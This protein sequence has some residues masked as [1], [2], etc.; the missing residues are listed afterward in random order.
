MNL[1]DDAQSLQDD[2]VHL[3]RLIHQEP[4]IGLQLPRTQEKVLTALDG[5]PGL[6]LTT[7]RGLDS[8]I[9]VVH[10]E[11]SGGGR[12]LLRADMDALPVQERTGLD[13]AAPGEVMHACGHDLHTA[14]LVGA[15]RLLSAH[16]DRLSGDVVLM[17][18]PG[19]EGYDGARH[20]ID[21][22]V[23]DAAG[24]P[25]D[26]AYALHVTSAIFPG[27]AISTRPGPLMASV[28]VL[29][30]NVRGTGG[31]ASAPHH[32]NDPIP[33]AAEMVTALQALV[34]RKF[35]IFDPIVIT[36]GSFHA[37]TQN[38]IIPEVATFDATVRT[39]S[40]EAQR[41]V[42]EQSVRLCRD[43][44]TA[45][46]LRADVEW[47]TQYPATINND[48]HAAFVA[49][50]AADLLGPDGSVPMPF[51]MA[52]AEDFSRVLERVPGAM[53]FLGAVPPGLDPADAPFNHSAYAA[54][55]E[56]VLASGAALY[57]ELA[58]RRL[59]S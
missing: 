58:L 42:R 4:E 44:A 29:H 11:Q 51:P 52:G 59:A 5:L 43:I 7:G 14:M 46:D 33:A 15:A 49:D 25:L 40:A 47:E 10:G 30:V 38:N 50:T 24:A 9:G 3:R 28:D 16:R 39:F 12:V 31:H 56:D 13:F 20:M 19:E 27:R 2:L 21:E 34:T 18:Q 37:G 54:F 23:L 41:R 6:E 22:G 45:H 48:A 1:I 8:V 17:F 55:D 26:A 35:N 36:V 53:A 57:A 32:A